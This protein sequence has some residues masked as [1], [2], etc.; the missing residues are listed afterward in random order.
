MPS[1]PTTRKTDT[2]V[3]RDVPLAISSTTNRAGTARSTCSLRRMAE[4]VGLVAFGALSP[5]R[6]AEVD[7]GPTA[8]TPTGPTSGRSVPRRGALIPREG[9]K[10]ASAPCL[11]LELRSSSHRKVSSRLRRMAEGVGLVAFGALSPARTAFF[12]PPE[13]FKSA[14]PNGG[15]GGI[16]TH[17]PLRVSGFQDRCNRPLYHPS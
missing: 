3:D 6:T 10:S 8:S 9:F 2:K 7:S 15:G 13:G 12:I 16:R 14:S 5:A 4:G 1:H 11:R 17:G